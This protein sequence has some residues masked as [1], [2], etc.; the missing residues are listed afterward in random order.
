MVPQ[1]GSP[2]GSG[3]GSGCQSGT[4]PGGAG[5]TPPVSPSQGNN[6]GAIIGPGAPNY[7]GG[8]GGG[9][10]AA[11]DNGGGNTP[12]N[13]GNGLQVQYRYK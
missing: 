7:L 5:N 8:G 10:G 11:A 1:L 9:A 6:G 2:G 4:V 12:G 13:G 3:G